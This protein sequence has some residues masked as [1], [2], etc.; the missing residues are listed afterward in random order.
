MKVGDRLYCY[1]DINMRTDIGVIIV[2]YYVITSYDNKYIGVDN[3]FY[4]KDCD[5]FKDT[6]KE[7]F[8]TLSELRKIKLDILGKSSFIGTE[9][10]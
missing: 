3:L 5:D 7:W 1:S 2:R 6:Y 4:I 9:D 8:L 10:F